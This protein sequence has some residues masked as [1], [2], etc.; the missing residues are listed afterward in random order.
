MITPSPKHLLTLNRPNH[1]GDRNQRHAP[2]GK[3][4][5][6]VRTRTQPITITTAMCRYESQPSRA[7][8]KGDG[9]EMVDHHRRTRAFIAATVCAIAAM[10]AA[11]VTASA[12]PLLKKRIVGGTTAPAGTFPWL[13]FVYMDTP[14]SW[15]ICTGTVVAPNVVLTAAHCAIDEN[16]SQV[17]PASESGVSEFVIERPHFSTRR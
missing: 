3:I 1:G 17:L 4:E 10:C 7:G 6:S 13:A 8:T 16:T 2:A 14:E 5:V 15:G 12:G 9:T 11:P